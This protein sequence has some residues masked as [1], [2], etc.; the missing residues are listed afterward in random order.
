[1]V[2]AVIGSWLS[3][4]ALLEFDAAPAP[5][6]FVSSKAERSRAP[7][8]LGRLDASHAGSDA[9]GILVDVSVLGGR[10][11]GKDN[12]NELGA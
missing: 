5:A 11:F 8:V 2:Q 12:R 10:L 6:G 7:L 3:A 4:V 1:V 9:L